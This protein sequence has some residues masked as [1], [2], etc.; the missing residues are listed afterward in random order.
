M[1]SMK[2]LNALLVEFHSTSYSLSSLK[3]KQSSS[4]ALLA[5]ARCPPSR[6][7][8]NPQRFCYL[9]GFLY[10]VLPPRCLAT[11]RFLPGSNTSSGAPS[12]HNS[13]QIPQNLEVHSMHWL[14][15]SCAFA[16]C[17]PDRAFTELSTILPPLSVLSSAQFLLQGVQQP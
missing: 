3:S 17:P 12:W 6:A 7:L 10:I 15:A 11:S 14:N 9:R 2:L 4:C 16:Q 1:H 5:L 8:Q 13:V